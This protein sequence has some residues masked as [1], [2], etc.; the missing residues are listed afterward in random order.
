MMVGKSVSISREKASMK[1]L[2]T[3]QGTEQGW[4]SDT[5]MHDQGP[6]KATYACL[7][8]SGSYIRLW[9]LAMVVHVSF[10]MPEPHALQHTAALR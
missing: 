1:S 9:P 10:S 3:G 2:Q 7:A 4:S 8:C 5:H 6:G